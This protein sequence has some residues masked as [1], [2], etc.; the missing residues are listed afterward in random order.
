MYPAMPHMA[1]DDKGTRAAAH[2]AEP[3]FVAT[4]VARG[5]NDPTQ[6]ISITHSM[7]E[8]RPM[9][10]DAD[11]YR[12]PA[13]DD[14]VDSLID[15]AAVSFAATPEDGSLWMRD[16]LTICNVRVVSRGGKIVGGLGVVPKGQFFGGRSVPMAGIAGVAVR[17]EH[18][19][20]GAALAM[21]RAM[22][23]EQRARG[24]PLS[25]LY[26][27]TSHLYRR[28]GYERAG[29]RLS[30]EVATRDIPRQADSAL[31]IRPVRDGDQ[32]ALEAC[33][34]ERAARTNGHLD[35]S[36]YNW[37]RIQLP[38]K[39]TS[40]GWLA[41]RDGRVESFV[42]IVFDRRPDGF[43]VADLTD[44][45]CATADGARAMAR[46]LGGLR[47][48]TRLMTWHSGL[49]DPFIALFSEQSY[50]T[51]LHEQWMLRIT[52]VPGALAA[53]G[54]P[55][56]LDVEIHLEVADDVIPENAGRW[57]LRIADGRGQ[58]ESGG[59]GDVRID[60]RALASLYSS[61]MTARELA[62]CDLIDAP[63][64]ALAT[65]E[66]AFCGATPWMP[67]MF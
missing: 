7:L 4:I 63:A 19:G 66:T 67:D 33:Y 30:F 12:V 36:R 10:I 22:L 41:E 42:Y 56:G 21:M 54:W 2:G 34:R 37:M 24:V 28:A 5:R 8:T 17:P 61:F 35:R 3:D 23:L 15:I 6:G 43:Q 45:T 48:M 64:A 9:G 47:S 59:R 27:S 65:V 57:I 62:A 14:E 29:W 31:E 58:V 18:R 46:F 51:R 26:A 53:R 39:R 38:H 25:T 50:S 1:G 44:L 52:D 32:P 11:S 16:R 40:R 60:V 49:S 20:A 55:A 13:N